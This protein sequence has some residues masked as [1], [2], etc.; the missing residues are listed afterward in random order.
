METILTIATVLGGLSA[1]W[2]FLEKFFSK[3]KLERDKSPK[4]VSSQ[5]SVKNVDDTEVRQIIQQYFGTEVVH[6]DPP[7]AVWGDLRSIG[8]EREFYVLY[9]TIDHHILDVFTTQPSGPEN[10]FHRIAEG[11]E[12]LANFTSFDGRTYFVCAAQS[13]SGS[14]M[15]IDIYAYDGIGKLSRVFQVSDLF[16]GHF[17]ISDGR[18]FIAGGNKR[19]E[20]RREDGSFILDAYDKKLEPP[21][22]AGTH[23][24]SF[25]PKAGRLSVMFDG[26]PLSFLKD[27]E[28]FRSASP[29]HL[30]FD[31]QIIEDDNLV[32]LPPQSIRLLV[33]RGKFHC[34]RHFF[35]TLKPAVRGSSRIQI[36]HNYGDWYIVDVSVE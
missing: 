4:S 17:W 13:G 8:V 35:Y 32:D 10:L 16:Q 36:S 5:A 21:Q 34:H 2:Y 23:I 11:E 33:E 6:V 30:H 31:E 25:S 9:S 12:L 19:Y 28:S 3:R 20:L 27:G 29:I 24:L 18:L 14:Y 22:S 7:G 1:A 15:V 26:K